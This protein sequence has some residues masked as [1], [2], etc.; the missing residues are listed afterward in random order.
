MNSE[1]DSGNATASEFNIQVSFLIRDTL[2]LAQLR[3]IGL[4][5]FFHCD[6][7]HQTCF[8]NKKRFIGD[9]LVDVV[10]ACWTTVFAQIEQN[11]PKQRNV[12]FVAQGCRQ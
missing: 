9:I 12:K 11:P 6:L 4:R 10:G 8:G 7:S 2:A 3:A 5:S 1:A